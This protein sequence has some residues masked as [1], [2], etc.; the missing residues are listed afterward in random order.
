ML[1]YVAEV[2]VEARR[3]A[4]LEIT[5]IDHQ[6]APTTTMTERRRIRGRYPV[7]TGV[8]LPFLFRTTRPRTV[9][10]DPDDFST[11]PGLPKQPMATSSSTSSKRPKAPATSSHA[12]QFLEDDDQALPGAGR[13]SRRPAGGGQQRGPRRRTFDR[14][15]G[16]SMARSG[17][18]GG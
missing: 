7:P 5:R 8:R 9:K 6:A 12:V 13:W 10:R 17:R 15:G 3:L 18:E 2:P 11:L 4:T 1:S 14:R 16:L